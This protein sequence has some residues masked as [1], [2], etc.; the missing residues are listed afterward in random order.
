[1]ALLVPAVA[2]MVLLAFFAVAEMSGWTPLSYEP[3]ANIAEA[4]G[5]A[6]ESELLRFLRQGQDP[7]A[8]Y[9][10]R[11]DI[12]SSSI[13][14]VTALEA[15]IWSRRVRMIDILEREGAI[16]SDETRRHLVCLAED[17]RADEL[18]EQLAPEGAHDC[19]AGH[20][21]RYVE[22]RSQ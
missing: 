19:A 3:P 7:S 5:M 13:T 1:V 8:V 12:I 6:M 11:P 14:R 20:A 10:V 21:S 18:A 9:E 22:A 15:A 16:G 4:A 17:I 2:A